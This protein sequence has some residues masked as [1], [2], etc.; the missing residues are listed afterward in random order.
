M[1]EWEMNKKAKSGISKKMSMYHGEE[2]ERDNSTSSKYSSYAQAKEAGDTVS[3]IA[4]KRANKGAKIRALSA[5]YSKLPISEIQSRIKSSEET[6]GK[7]KAIVDRM[8]EQEYNR[9]KKEYSKIGGLVGIRLEGAIAET[10]Q[11]Y[12]RQNEEFLKAM[13]DY[14]AIK[15]EN[16]ALKNAKDAYIVANQSLIEEEKRKFQRKELLDS[17]ILEELG[18]TRREG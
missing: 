3:M 18:I 12:E 15:T 9:L 10:M 4:F 7:A 2:P 14:N 16:R 13:A 17:G 1:R 11:D 6:L 5:E 8:R